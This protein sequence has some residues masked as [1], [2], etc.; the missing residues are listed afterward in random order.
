MKLDAEID[1]LGALYFH[2]L[3]TQHIQRSFEASKASLIR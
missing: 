1:V 2:G 3:W